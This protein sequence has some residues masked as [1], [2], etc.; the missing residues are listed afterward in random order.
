MLII[1]GSPYSPS[2]KRP[3]RR[4]S[5]LYFSRPVTSLHSDTQLWYRRGNWETSQVL[6]TDISYLLRLKD[7]RVK[8]TSLF[9]GVT[10][11]VQL[12]TLAV[13]NLCH[14]LF[15]SPH[16]CKDHTQTGQLKVRHKI[17]RSSGHL[18]PQLE[19]FLAFHCT[20]SLR[21]KRAGL[22]NLWESLTSSGP[23]WPQYNRP[24]TDNYQR[25]LSKT[26]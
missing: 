19:A 9:L 12:E 26:S 1:T 3:A 18:G 11:C 14:G 20:V 22:S 24:Q 13:I 5:I 21:L 8:L 17:H 2:L 15:G 10:P 7:C 16:H 23:D 25:R 4:C 6:L